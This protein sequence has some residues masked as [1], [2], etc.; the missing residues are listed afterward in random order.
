MQKPIIMALRRC[1][2]AALFVLLT[3]N[4]AAQPDTSTQDFGTM[5]LQELLK[6]KIATNKEQVLEEAPSIVSVI[7]KKEIAAYGCREMSDVLRLVPGFEFGADLLGLVGLRFRGIWTQEG[8]ALLMLN[9]VALND[10]GYGSYSYI[11]TLPVS[12]IERVEIIRGPGSALYGAF[13][14]VCVI[15]IITVPPGSGNNIVLSANSGLVG[16]KGYALDGNLSATGNNGDLRYNFNIGYAERPLSTREYRDFFGNSLKLDNESAFRKWHH[17]ITELGYKG[18]TFNFHRTFHDYNGRNGFYMIADNF[19]GKSQDVYNQTSNAT[20]LK[21]DAKIGS[22]LNLTPQVEFISGNSGSA[23]HSPLSVT[24]IY[25]LNGRQNMYRIRGQITGRYNF[26]KAGELTVGA[27]YSRDIVKNA[28][29]LGTP[30]L[31]SPFGDTVFSLYTESRYVLFQY[32]AKI[33]DF[34]FIAGSRYESTSFGE[35]LAPRA[36]ITFHKN[37][38]NFKILYGKAYRIPLP[39]QA[40]SRVITFYPENKL[41]PELTGTA[42]FEVGYKVNNNIKAKLN[43]FIID[44]DKPISYRSSDNSYHNFGKIQSMG[45][46]AELTAQYRKSKAFLNFSYNKPGKKTSAPFV[47]A[48]KENFLAMPSFKINLGGFHEFGKWTIGP[49]LTWLSES[50][51]ESQDHALGL[52]TGYDNTRYAPVLLTNLNIAYKGLIKKVTIN[53]S[54]HNLFDAKYLLVQPYYGAHAPLPGNDRQITLGAR[55]AL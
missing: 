10:L 12:I 25:N 34:G 41:E 48:D 39:W 49:T 5:S 36:G 20:S 13:A 27:G 1:L 45:M 17:I 50:F 9:G 51:G 16:S 40:Y 55:L 29:A 3:I 43:A 31:S 24:G 8:K 53:V 32:M 2:Y 14:E 54:A 11:G 4:A 37:K 23:A 21:Y 35:A 38:V 22:K 28:S 52:T 15:N 6:V 33:K 19:L 44:I 30:G 26:G 42:E 18:L 7:S 47:T 46:E